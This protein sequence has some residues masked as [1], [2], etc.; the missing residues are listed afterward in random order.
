M[1]QAERILLTHFVLAAVK[2]GNGLDEQGVDRILN[3]GVIKA[4]FPLHEGNVE[5]INDGP[6]TERQVVIIF[7]R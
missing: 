3:I 4:M 6:L 2:F 1:T 5:W 7:F